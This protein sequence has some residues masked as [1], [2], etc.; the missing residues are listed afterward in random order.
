MSK[1]KKNKT[2]SKQ[3]NSSKKEKI[4]ETLNLE[5]TK[6]RITWHSIMLGALIGMLSCCSFLFAYSETAE[7]KYFTAR[8]GLCIALTIGVGT[9]ATVLIRLFLVKNLEPKDVEGEEEIDRRYMLKTALIIFLCWTPYIIC[10]WPGAPL[11]DAIDQ[12]S[13]VLF[14]ENSYTII[15]LGKLRLDPEVALNSHHPIFTSFIMAFFYKMGAVVFHNP[16]HGIGIMITLICM[17]TA[18]GMGYMLA[19][20]K[21]RKI[22]RKFV[23]GTFLFFALCYVFPIYQTAIEKDGFF[24]IFFIFAQVELIKVIEKPEL[25]K[26]RAQITKII[27][28]SVL[29]MLTRHNAIYVCILMAAFMYIRYKKTAI[30]L[31]AAL[32]IASVVIILTNS[33][34]LP[35]FKVTPSD[36]T[37]AWSIPFITIG[38]CC[39]D[40]ADE[41]TESEKQAVIGMLGEDGF[42][43]NPTLADGIALAYVDHQMQEVVATKE[44]LA[45]LKA[46]VALGV[47]HPLTYLEALLRFWA[48]LYASRIE[49]DY[50]NIP[51]CVIINGS[52]D[53][54][55]GYE[56]PHG[57]M[58]DL[59]LRTP[60]K[61]EPIADKF[62]FIQSAIAQLPVL[63]TF[64]RTDIFFWGMIVLL[65]L[66][67]YRRRLKDNIGMYMLSLLTLLS[68]VVGP[69]IYMRY[70]E[71]LAAVFPLLMGM[72]LY[73][74]KI[75]KSECEQIEEGKR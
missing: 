30:K 35:A 29:M 24:T 15:E 7:L 37:S 75:V 33:L 36:D 38:K 32:A 34:V 41:F 28:W 22:N 50:P 49:V 18:L 46:W 63:N 74:S 3:K 72:T 9:L 2:Q 68:L 44:K 62:N 4:T 23:N 59:G 25:M 21:S 43:F 31:S 14:P 71:P 51:S 42:T 67:K 27:I 26:D 40:H 60:E 73:K 70:Y 54:N 5:A 69:I 61:L 66:L 57:I 6:K 58:Q 45:F 19:Y 13:Q 11:S 53:D 47:K 48:P 55:E 20:M 16:V 64:Y 39:I 65:M 8:P 10:R 17:A 1:N 56:L 12:I 52:K